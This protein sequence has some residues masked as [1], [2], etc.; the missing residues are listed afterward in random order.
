[1]ATGEP[2][3]DKIAARGLGA[4]PGIG[5]GKVKVLSG[6][7][8]I[9]RMEKGEVLVTDMTTPDFVPAM[10][11]ATAIVTNSGGMTCFDGAT[12]ILTADGFKTIAQVCEMQKEGNEIQVLSLNEKTLKA[13]WKSVRNSFAR[14][15]KAIRIKVSRLVAQNKIRLC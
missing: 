4:A 3:A 6:P 9:G 12:R 7:K 11:K 14:K 8:E 1:M 2:T 15:A 5:R 13:E 10:K